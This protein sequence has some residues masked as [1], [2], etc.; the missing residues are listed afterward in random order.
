[1]INVLRIA[2]CC[3]PAVAITLAVS[4]TAFAQG[5]AMDK[6]SAVPPAGQ[7]TQKTIDE[8]AKVAVIDFV[9]KPGE[10]SPMQKRPMRVVYFVSGGNFERTY[11]DGK[12]EV[13]TSKAGETKIL[14]I[15]QPYALKNIGKTTIHTIVVNVK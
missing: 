14:D 4:S 9:A 8:N 13:I 10:T 1:M 7:W 6:M 15:S 2:L 11:A 5:M 12:K 3:V